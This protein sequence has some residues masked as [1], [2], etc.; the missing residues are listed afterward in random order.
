MFARLHKSIYGGRQS[1]KPATKNTG[2]ILSLGK[3]H[4]GPIPNT[5]IGCLGF[6]YH[7]PHFLRHTSTTSS[8]FNS[9]SALALCSLT[10]LAL[11]LH[12]GA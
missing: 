8:L 1:I 10:P 11:S 9:C 12:V 6:H 4:F 7:F 5:H 2:P 3:A